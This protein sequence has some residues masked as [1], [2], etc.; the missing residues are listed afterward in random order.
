MVGTAVLREP[1]SNGSTSTESSSA[2]DRWR[3]WCSSCRRRCPRTKSC[4]DEFPP[5][6]WHSRRRDAWVHRKRASL[7]VSRFS[8][9][10]A[11]GWT[12]SDSLLE[13]T[14][15][16]EPSLWGPASAPWLGG[17]RP[18]GR[19]PLRTPMQRSPNRSAGTGRHGPDGRWPRTYLA[20]GTS[21]GGDAGDRGGDRADG[22][23]SACGMSLFF[24]VVEESTPVPEDVEASLEPYYSQV[25]RWDGA[26]NS[27]ARPPRRRWIGTIRRQTRSSSRSSANPREEDRIGSLFVNPGGPGVS[28]YDFVAGCARRRRIRGVAGSV[29]HH[30]LRPSRSRTIDGRVVLRRGGARQRSSTGLHRGPAAAIR[31]SRRR[32]S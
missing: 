19:R 12:P 18:T 25:L 15:C 11:T 10:S 13:D 5:H 21:N 20:S 9:A 22:D 23:L 2:A 27:S 3:L 31:G 32:T 24:P 8:M 4:H 16:P 17:T 14:Y 7:G 6:V 29:R 30:R 28:G 26:A 1:S